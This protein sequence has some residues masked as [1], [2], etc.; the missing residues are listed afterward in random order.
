MTFW[1]VEGPAG[2]A[3]FGTFLEAVARRDQWKRLYGWARL[4]RH[5]VR[6]RAVEAA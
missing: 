5:V 1:V 2:S 4:T 3:T 6:R